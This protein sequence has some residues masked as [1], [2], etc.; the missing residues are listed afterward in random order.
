MSQ[1]FIVESNEK[2]VESLNADQMNKCK[3][4]HYIV[5]GNILNILLSTSTSFSMLNNIFNWMYGQGNDPKK[6][7]LLWTQKNLL[8]ILLI[9]K[10]LSFLALLSLENS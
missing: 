4:F 6:Q 5:D 3:L 8:F 2:T 7:N 1:Y 10:Y 9:G